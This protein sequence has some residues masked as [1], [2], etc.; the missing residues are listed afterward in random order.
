MEDINLLLVDDE[1]EF[2][3]TLA[4]RLNRRGFHALYVT[5]ARDA[6]ERI[7][8][9]QFDVAVVDVRMPEMDGIALLGE[10]KRVQPLVE[11][12]LLTGYASIQSGI[13]GMKRGAFDYLMKPTDIDE[14][15]KKIRDAYERKK[16]QD[17]KISR[18]EAKDSLAGNRPAD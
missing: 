11:V 14:L 2:V 13:E 17:E 8:G 10:V 9:G 16:Q 4:K 3:E 12:I 15:V 18:A 1:I 6:M 5:S 7:K